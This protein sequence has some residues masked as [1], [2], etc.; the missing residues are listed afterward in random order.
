MFNLTAEQA[1]QGLPL[2]FV[3]NQWPNSAKGLGKSAMSLRSSKWFFMVLPIDDVF[4]A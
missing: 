2:S 4:V 3:K 1:L